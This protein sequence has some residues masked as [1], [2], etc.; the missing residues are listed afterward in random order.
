MKK[1]F[2]SLSIIL[3]VFF[4]N[5][6]PNLEWA[7]S[8][9][10]DV[11]NV[12]TLKLSIDSSNNI[13]SIGNY[14]TNTDFDPGVGNTNTLCVGY[15]DGYIRKLSSSGSLI[16]LKTLNGAYN[17]FCSGITIDK[18]QNIYVV[19]SF[20]S[21]VDFDPGPGIVN[22]SSVLNNYEDIFILK[23]DPNGNFLWVKTFGGN[24]QNNDRAYEVITD[25]NGDV[26]VAGYFKDSIDFDP[27]PNTHYLSSLNTFS[28]YLLKLD[29]NG[30]FLWIENHINPSPSSNAMH[31]TVDQQNNIYYSANFIDS[32]DADPSANINML[33][34]NGGDD[35]YIQKLTPGGQLIWAK[36]FGSNQLDVNQFLKVDNSNNIVIS[37]TYKAIMDMDPGLGTQ[38]TISYGNNDICIFSL[39]NAGDFNWGIFYGGPQSDQCTSLDFDSNGNMYATGNFLGT[40][41]FDPGINNVLFTSNG[42]TESFIQKFD[43]SRN[44]KWARSI[45]G[46][47]YD[48]GN[49]IKIDNEQKIIGLGSYKGNVDFDPNNSFYHL[50]TLGDLNTY[51]LIWFE[52]NIDSSISQNGTTLTANQNNATYQWIQC[53]P[54][55]IIA[56][57]TSQTFTP[58]S[59][60]SYAVII[61]LNGCSDTSNCFEI[62]TVSLN[63]IDKTENSISIAP[64]PMNK[65]CNITLPQ[66]I[67]DAHLEVFNTIGQSIF[68]D[69][70]DGNTYE[71]KNQSYSKG[72][73]FIKIETPAGNRF[74]GKLIIE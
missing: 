26:L 33:Y 23:L 25:N 43:S 34:S 42:L 1:I 15:N 11:N 32:I 63:E 17:Q 53:N 61:N 69:K 73:Y 19:G 57:V 50:D 66:Q 47:S 7:N 45:G 51:V 13:L 2:L 49:A 41:D 70:F 29:G 52:C 56:G 4:V 39:N 20:C 48:Y 58:L 59:N 22:K 37:C 21:T 54:F 35:F 62:S 74:T 14:T 44:F 9:K 10:N 28:D 31:V 18:F 12:I 46:S 64:N 67:N 55:S 16:W 30:N 71:F 68:E 40:V 38:N 36:S 3:S 8:I 72:T 60:G 6:Q 5:A 24:F 27:G 65:N